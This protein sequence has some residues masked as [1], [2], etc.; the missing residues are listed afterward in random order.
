MK[1]ILLILAMC[2]LSGCTYQQIN[3]FNSALAGFNSAVN[4]IQRERALRAYE[5]SVYNPQPQTV[6]VIHKDETVR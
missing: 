5:A 4:A 1:A 3:A 2:S 6:V